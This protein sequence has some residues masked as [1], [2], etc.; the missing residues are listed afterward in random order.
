MN[1][2][3]RRSDSHPELQSDWDGAI[4]RQAETLEVG[5]FRSEG[6]DHRPQTRA[7]LLYDHECLYGIYDVK[8]RYV[9]CVH[10]GFQEQVSRDSCV[11]F[12]VQPKPDRGYFNFEFNCGGALLCY[13]ILDP[14][15]VGD[16]FKEYSIL[17]QEECAQVRIHHSLPAVVEPEL[18]EETGWRLEF[19]IP[20]SLL[21]K[22]V[23]A[24]GAVPGREW[25]AN[26]YKCGERTT[27]PHYA[28]WA[29]LDRLDFH[30]P[31]CFGGITFEK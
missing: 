1:Y 18:E 26:L 13:Y 28:A 25:R 27:H 3:V 12:F 16:G 22:Y 10:T 8:D 19:C 6:S 21:E 15:R 31:R 17:T 23:G 5:H 30:L 2:L 9:R 14:T 29:P 24:L 4:W 20:F 7:R 11:E